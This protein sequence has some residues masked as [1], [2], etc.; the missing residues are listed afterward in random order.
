VIN[1]KG[2]YLLSQREDEFANLVAEGMTNREI[3][4]KLGAAEHTVSNYLFRIYEKL[5]ISSRVELVLYVLKQSRRPWRLSKG[6]LTPAGAPRKFYARP[7]WELDACEAR[8]A[9]CPVQPVR[10]K[11]LEPARVTGVWGPELVTVIALR[12]VVFIGGFP[13]LIEV[14]LT[15][16]AWLLLAPDAEKLAIKI[17]AT[18]LALFEAPRRPTGAR[19]LILKK[20]V[21]AHVHG[22]CLLQRV[23]R[24]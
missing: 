19:L 12:G 14:G 3:A 22:I 8:S 11:A 9:I 4:Q 16:M 13:K 10:V 24:A 23:E 5:G 20:C 2:R 18:A 21:A 7:L 6:S 17:D 15:E 1:S